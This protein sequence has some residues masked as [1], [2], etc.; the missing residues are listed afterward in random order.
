MKKERILPYWCNGQLYGKREDTVPY[1]GE[2][3]VAW[4]SEICTG[5]CKSWG[6]SQ[7]LVWFLCIN[8]C[9]VLYIAFKMWCLSAY[10]SKTH[11]WHSTVTPITSTV[12]SDKD[13]FQ[14]CRLLMMVVAKI[15]TAMDYFTEWAKA[16][17]KTPDSVSCNL[18]I[19]VNYH[20]DYYIIFLVICMGLYHKLLFLLLWYSPMH[21]T[22]K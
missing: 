12:K 18:Y 17:P 11:N 4:N 10:E 22:K 15:L 16:L 1:E 3:H 6:Y 2:V 8:L 9:I 5:S 19:L 7:P 21:I 20:S 14:Y 13:W